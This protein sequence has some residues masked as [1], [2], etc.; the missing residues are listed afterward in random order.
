VSH[1]IK[2]PGIYS[3]GTAIE[4]N[5]SWKRNVVRFRSLDLMAKRLKNLEN[6]MQQLAQKVK[7][8]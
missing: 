7:E 1:S 6:E 8:K 3:S 4:P 2:T 5:R